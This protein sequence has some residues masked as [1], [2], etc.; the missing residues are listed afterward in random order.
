MKR[1]IRI[2]PRGDESTPI[3][4]L[5]DVGAWSV[6]RHADFPSAA[7]FVVT[8]KN[9]NGFA[10]KDDEAVLAMATKLWD[11]ARAR[12]NLRP[13]PFPVTRKDFLDKARKELAK[14]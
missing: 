8:R 7:P 14:R 9:W 3:V 11:E 4:R 6:V 5:G 10:L 1:E 13:A 2:M 12:L